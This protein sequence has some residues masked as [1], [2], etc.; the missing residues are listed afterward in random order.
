M[1]PDEDSTATVMH[2]FPTFEAGGVQMR[3]RSLIS[4]ESPK[5]KHVVV[6]LDG[7]STDPSQML[8]GCNYEWIPIPKAGSWPTI[9]RIRSI[10]VDQR[11]NLLLSYD[12]GAIESVVAN[13]ISLRVPHVHHEDGVEDDERESEKLR[14]VIARRLILRWVHRVVVPS[15]SRETVAAM[16]WNI[17]KHKLVRIPN[18]VDLQRFDRAGNRK[19]T[20]D[21]W[22]VPEGSLVVGTVCRLSK[23]KNIGRLL[24][25]V[26]RLAPAVLPHL[27]VCGDG[28]DR[29]HLEGQARALGI[30]GRVHWLG[31]VERPE[32]AY[33]AFDVFALTSDREE[34]P[35]ALLEA[36]ASGCAVVATSVGDIP[37]MMP[38]S[39]K[40]LLADT[41]VVDPVT[42][43][44]EALHRLLG[45]DQ[46]RSQLGRDN[47]EWAAS[48]HSSKHMVDRYHS[49]YA[50][51]LQ[52]PIR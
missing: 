24:E 26:N 4:F 47:R 32:D 23:V 41:A 40:G 13:R 34:Q 8:R 19:A 27:V 37:A 36:M 52:G 11:P 15:R 48:H 29:R 6:T 7:S 16:R 21:S 33:A 50:A 31:H 2:V 1:M 14:R 20:L 10:I 18:G 49:L 9:S 42:T 44:T 30:E 46:L 12:W 17:P 25:A 5:R 38:D 51:A 39:Q 43:L 3:T 35:L 28:P 22:G 45:D